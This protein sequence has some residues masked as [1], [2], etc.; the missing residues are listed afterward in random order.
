MPLVS[1]LMPAYNHEEYVS[2]AVESVLG[3]THKNL[4]LIVIDD[5]SSDGTWAVL[6][7]FQDH[8]LRRYRHDRNQGAHATLNEAM[9]LAQGEYIAILDSDDRYDPRR[10]ERLLSEVGRASGNDVFIFSDVDFIGPTGGGIADHPRAQGYKTQRKR[11]E[12]LS[13]ASWFFASNLAMTTSN[14]FF[15]RSL[16]NRVGDFSPLR[17][18]HDWDWALRATLQG[19]IPLWV[20]EDLLAYRVHGANTLSEG[21]LW[22]HIHENSYVQARALLSL[23]KQ[24]GEGSP[25]GK[26]HG[27]DILLALMGNESLHPISLLCYL[28]Y[29]LAGTENLCLLDCAGGGSTGWRLQRLA[30]AVA[31]PPGVFRSMAHLAERERAIVVQAAMLDERWQ[32]MEQMRREIAGQKAMVEDRWA[33][34]QQMSGEIASRN[35]WIDDLSTVVKEKEHCI[36]AQGTMLDERWQAMEQM[37]KEIAQRDAQLETARA[38]IQ[39]LNRNLFIRAG[40][41][42]RRMLAAL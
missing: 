21:D 18:T 5:A 9:A 15:S 7:S 10:L 12:T 17:Y 4:E 41:Y 39:K 38:E 2:S 26:A 34:I 22:R 11:W 14:F 23:G 29:G 6:Q 1:V 28:V 33:T 42:L 16:A 24:L 31:C 8:R 30:E 37:G 25:E 13:P 40:R 20:R 35:Q 3:Q 36:S 19:T 32:A 27:E